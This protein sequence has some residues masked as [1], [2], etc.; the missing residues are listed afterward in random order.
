MSESKSKLGHTSLKQG[1]MGPGGRVLSVRRPYKRWLDV[2]CA[3][4]LSLPSEPPL[5]N[6]FDCLALTSPSVRFSSFCKV[7]FFYHRVGITA[8]HFALDTPIV[9]PA[10]FDGM[11]MHSTLFMHNLTIIR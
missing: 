5:K 9:D 1:T 3:P 4:S 8:R 6:D 2:S 10:R 11:P 7:L